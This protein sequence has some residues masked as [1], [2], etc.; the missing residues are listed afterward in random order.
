VERSITQAAAGDGRAAGAVEDAEEAFEDEAFDWAPLAWGLAIVLLCLAVYVSIRPNRS[1]F[2]V[3]FVW[4]AQAWLDG[5]TTIPT[6]VPTTDQSPGDW[7]YHD[8]QPVLDADGFPTDRGII[9]FPP[10]P[11]LALVPFVAVWHLFTGEQLLAAVFGAADVGL[12]YWMLGYLPIP[13][14]IRRLTALFFGLG[15]ALFYTSVIGTTWFWAHVV[16]LGCL[17]PAVGLALSADAAAAEPRASAVER[18]ARLPRWPGGWQSAACLISL[19]ALSLTLLQLAGA[20]APAW[21]VAGAGLLAALAAVALAVAVSGRSAALLP[22][23]L[24]AAIV[25]GIPGAFLVQA[26]SPEAHRLASVAL[27]LAAAMLALASWRESERLDALLLAM[28]RALRRPE[29]RQVAAGLLF[30][31]ACTARL[32]ILVGFPFLL[33]VGGGRSWLRRGLLAGAGAAV[34]LL[35]LLVYTYASTGHVF[36]PA[37][38][39]LYRLELGYPFNYHPDWSIEDIRYVP[40]NL[41][42][43]L[44]NGPLITPATLPLQS[45]QLCAAGQARGIFDVSCPLAM[46][47]PI[48]MSVP[49]TSPA[50]LLAPL[51]FLGARRRGLDRL[52]VAAA[53]AVL[54]IAFVNLMHFSQGWVQFGYRFANDFAPFALILVA[55]AATRLRAP[56]LLAL[57]VGFSIA[58]NFWGVMWGLNLGW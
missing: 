26:W 36:N 45:D 53:L 20:G 6:G 28:W 7:W 49:L 2:Y 51:A 21:A 32:T 11:A 37:Y 35:A 38:E 4:Q 41:A 40:Q 3:H 25:C 1:D 57:L 54:A 52:T 5:E 29:T 22:F 9:P 8:V 50:Y 17:L 24:V 48:G 15:T 44:F 27:G 55:L 23:V 16:A 43:F 14:P 18:A 34:P 33:L 13:P 10:L 31:L 46:P 56:W 39:Y 42:I 47:D 12:A 58:V 19:A 30:G